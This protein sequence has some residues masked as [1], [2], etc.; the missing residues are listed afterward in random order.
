MVKALTV[1]LNSPYSN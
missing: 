1:Q